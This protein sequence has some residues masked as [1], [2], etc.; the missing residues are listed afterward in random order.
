VKDWGRI[1]PPMLVILAL[2]AV[3]VWGVVRNR[4]WAYPAVWLFG[5]LAPSSSFV[6]IVDVIFEH[7]MYL[8]LAGVVVLVVL[9]GY[10]LFERWSARR[11]G[12]ILVA[13]V[14][15]VLGLLTLQRN[16][17]YRSGVSIWQ[18]VLE[19]APD[20]ARAH[21]SIGNALKLEG[22]HSEAINHYQQAIRLKPTDA[23]AYNNLGGVLLA[24]GRLD[25]AADY[26][27]QA[28][29]LM[30]DYADAY[31]NLGLAA[32]L[33]G[34]TDEAIGYFQQAL[35]VK[36]SDGEAHYNLGIALLSQGKVDDAISQLRLSI[37]T[38]PS[39]TDAYYKLGAALKAQ[40]KLDEAVVAFRE[41]LQLRPDWILP[42]ND[43][44]LIL[45]THPDPNIRDARQAIVFAE[46]AARLTQ[47][48]NPAVLATLSV[49]YAAAGR[50]DDAISAAEAALPLTSA[51]GGEQLANI[52]RSQLALYKK[53]K[54]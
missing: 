21:N 47:Y 18:K 37:Q 24:K 6:P 38:K 14:I 3:T 54:Q 20:N 49:A 35:Q 42:L 51:Q 28:V 45:A 7:R 12:L 4:L 52:I 39:N 8:P 41:A 46:R 40:G 9:T 31:T 27:Q 36:P 17:D 29:R 48:R 15:I 26:F 16:R 50:I 5:I 44:S 32:A 2:L 25:E 19:V 43:I 33:Q 30:P 22:K 53:A 1:L 34:R 11:A 10:I 23:S 13:A